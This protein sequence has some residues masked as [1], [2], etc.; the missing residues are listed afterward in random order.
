MHLLKIQA[1]LRRRLQQNRMKSKGTQDTD[2][3]T[4]GIHMEHSEMLNV[5]SSQPTN[6]NKTRKWEKTE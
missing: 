6:W 4:C 3:R 1:E 2:D 5:V